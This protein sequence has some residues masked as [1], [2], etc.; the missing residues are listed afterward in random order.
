M[1][2]Y[3]RSVCLLLVLAWMGG[4]LVSQP[5]DE[6]PNNQEIT[7]KLVDGNEPDRL[8]PEVATTPETQTDQHSHSGANCIEE[9]CQT[10]PA[11]TCLND[12]TLRTFLGTG[13][14]HPTED[15]CVF[16]HK[17]TTCTGTCR[18]GACLDKNDPCATQTCNKPPAS[19]CTDAKTL[20]IYTAAGTCKAGTCSY[21]H[22]DQTCP[23][24]CAKGSCKSDPCA[25]QSCTKPPASTC[26]NSKT[27]RNYYAP[28]NCKAGTCSYP[29]A[30]QTCP[31]GCSKGACVVGAGFTPLNPFRFLDTRGSTQPAS[32]ST[33]CITIAGKGGVSST[34]RAVYINL[35][36]VAPTGIGFLTAYPKGINR[37]STSTLNYTNGNTIA[38]GAIV[39]IGTG[40]QICLFVKTSAHLIVDVMGFFDTDA[41]Y[42]PVGPYRRLDTRQTTQPGNDSTTCTK[43]A[44]QNGIPNTAKAIFA[45]LVAVTPTGPGFLTAYAKGNKRPSSSNLNYVTGETIA[46]GS[47]IPLNSTGEVCVY[48]K[49]ATHI[50]IDVSGY[51]G[52]ASSFFPVG[53]VRRIDTRSGSIIPAN[54]T[55]CYQV[56]ERN[57]IP[58]GAR[59]LA[60]NLAAITPAQPGHLILYPDGSP[61][62]TTSSLNHPTG[63]ARANNILVQPGTNGK[64]CVYNLQKTH[65]AL[66]ISGYWKGSAGDP[67]KGVTCANPPPTT[68]T[69]GK[70]RI[71]YASKGSCTNGTCIYKQ[72]QTTCDYRCSGNK[73]IPKPKP[74]TPTFKFHPVTAWQ[75]PSQPIRSGSAMSISSLRYITIHYNGGNL[76]LDG[77]DNVYQDSDFIQILRNTQNGYLTSRGYSL[78][79]NSAIAPNGDEWE[80]RGL[81]YRCAA[82]GCTAVN[83]PGYAIIIML[84]SITATPTQAQIQGALAAI[85]RV[86]AAVKAAGN[87]H[88]L[89]ING[90][91]D[92]RP[93]CGSGGTACPGDKLYQL[94]KNGTLK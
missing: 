64:V 36:A 73:C 38:N 28:G 24:G 87:P 65:Y 23:H 91:R 13:S 59:A 58:K 12:T 34:A 61:R 90:H 14:C 88:T 80:I 50:I 78:G 77:K 46:N 72:T 40:G 51:F 25:S 83:K 1:R 70:T 17:D 2:M 27:L 66:D 57:G 48:A 29:H 3:I 68:C 63:N 52:A 7:I 62:P 75:L 79:Y 6:R 92:V 56:T 39:K 74:P 44:G 15:K 22:T 33:R 76:D 30:D 11:P 37:P 18:A 84:P 10:P 67:C 49:T 82:N 86:R 9:E 41:D 93:L 20:R 45:N 16:S 5:F 19:T 31:R 21:P 47:I 71:T 4:C 60:V 85:A 81:R 32:D 35:V 53:P 94:I 54:T 55:K 26:T 89:T 43:I 69:G 42:F 8:P